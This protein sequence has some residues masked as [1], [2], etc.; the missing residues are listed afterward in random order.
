M[1]STWVLTVYGNLA[2]SLPTDVQAK[3]HDVSKA[4]RARILSH[5]LTKIPN[6]TAFQDKLADASSDRYESFLGSVG[7]DWNKDEILMKQ[8]VKLNR[9][10]ADWDSGVDS[11]FAVD[12]AFEKGVDNKQ[13]KL[14][15]LRYPMGLVGK[16]STDRWRCGSLVALALGGDTRIARYITSP[17]TLAGTIEVA[18]KSPYNVYDRPLVVASIVKY[19]TLAKFADEADDTTVRDACVTALDTIMTEV[20]GHKVTDST[21]AITPSWDD[22]YNHLKVIVDYTKPA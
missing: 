6:V 17:D 21:L 4:E 10:Y 1:P 20:E 22:T 14:E 8:R 3:W 11:A 19:G 12:G 13:G 15:A 9:K 5:L 16:K 7:G 2:D 18:L